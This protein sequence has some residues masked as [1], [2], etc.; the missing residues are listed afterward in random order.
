MKKQS[1]A[2]VAR[3]VR[4]PVTATE[5]ES[6][7]KPTLTP[8]HFAPTTPNPKSTDQIDAV[9]VRQFGHTLAQRRARRHAMKEKR[10]KHDI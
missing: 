10:T 3:E 6:V 1:Y 2:E 5:L 4:G 8:S 7:A 9:T